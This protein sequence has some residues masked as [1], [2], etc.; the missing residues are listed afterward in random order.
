MNLKKELLT[1]AEQGDA[2]AQFDLGNAYYVSLIPNNKKAVYWYERAAR[3][4]HADV[5]Y[6]QTAIFP[7]RV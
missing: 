2:K 1:L 5:Q 4:G 6:M 7:E 3:Q